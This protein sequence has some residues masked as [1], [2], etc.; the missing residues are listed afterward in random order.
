MR[1]SLL[2]AIIVAAHMLTSI[3]V[4]SFVAEHGLWGIWASV[5]RLHES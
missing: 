2:G 1:V 5:V 3:A 4:I